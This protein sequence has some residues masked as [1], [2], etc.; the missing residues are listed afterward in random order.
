MSLN[1]ESSFG[2]IGCSLI[3]VYLSPHNQ[4]Q[5][6]FLV[7]YGRYLLLIRQGSYLVSSF[8]Q[9]KFEPGR[10]I[11]PKNDPDEQSGFFF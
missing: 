5:K 10:K 7:G 11:A 2:I 3:S 8:L 9:N 4:K 1:N 6:L